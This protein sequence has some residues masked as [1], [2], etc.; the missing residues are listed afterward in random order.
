MATD[1]RDLAITT[2]EDLIKD[3]QAVASKVTKETLDDETG[4][5]ATVT[6]FRAG[7]D[8][9]PVKKRRVVENNEPLCVTPEDLYS[10]HAR[11]RIAEILEDW[12]MRKKA[13]A[14]ELLHRMDLVEQLEAGQELQH[15]VQ[16]VAVP[17]ATAR[18]RNT[19]EMMRLFH[20]LV[21]RA[22]DRL[23][24][25]KK[26]GAIPDFRQEPFEKAAQRLAGQPDAAFLL[27]GGIA[28]AIEDAQDWSEKLKLLLDLCDAAPKTGTA[29]FLAMTSLQQPLAEI[30]SSRAGLDGIVGK[31]PHLGASLAALTRLAAADAVEMLIKVERSVARVMPEFSPEARRLGKW[32]G[33][34]DFAEVRAA[35]GKRILTELNGPRRLCPGDAETEIHVLRALAMSLTAAAGK[36][37][38]AEDVAAAFSTRS[39]ML[40]AGDFVESYLGQGRTAQ[41]EAES[42]VWLA[43]N[44]IGSSNK[45][46]AARWLQA[47]IVHQRYEKEAASP[48]QTPPV[49]LQAL[50]S[51]QRSVGRCG[52]APE[53][54]EPIQ[55]WLGELGGRIE[56]EARLVQ[57]LSKAN[58]PVVQK[59]TYLLK[60]A[61]GETAPLGPA[62]DRA[63]NEALSL[64]RDDTV[65]AELTR[66][67]EQMSAIAELI[68]TAG[69]A[70]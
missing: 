25:A 21:D 7:A 23:K 63:R 61:S 39:K 67:A 46:H 55:T 9:A 6:V 10:I 51:L 33:S 45:R 37:L 70:A 35:L 29:R 66:D 54:S 50:A 19:H 62:A 4:E 13:T 11:L 15:A 32:L 41:Q 69:L 16:K 1:K 31:S 47:V 53:D 42:L 12:L 38:A 65:R 49:R 59:L 28:Q 43:E 22:I 40:V 36:L 18:G 44:V 52:L 30:V 24:Q 48:T 14:F 58:A 68:K 60:L 5:F 34:E 3:G 2:A 56:A 26:R 17:E 20:R 64:V 8:D 27:S 57:A